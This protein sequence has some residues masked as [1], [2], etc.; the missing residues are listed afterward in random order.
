M[1]AKTLQRCIK[2]AKD[3]I[4]AAEAVPLREVVIEGESSK[5]TVAYIEPGKASGAM[6]RASM[7]LSRALA[8]LRQGR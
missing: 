7:D 2:E 1:E 5:R 8:D 4:E 3:F 6:R